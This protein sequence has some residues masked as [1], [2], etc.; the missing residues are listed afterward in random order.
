MCVCH[1]ISFDGCLFV[2]FFEIYVNDHVDEFCFIF[3]FECHTHKT[4]I[5]MSNAK[6]NCCNMQS[7][8]SLFVGGYGFVVNDGCLNWVNNQMNQRFSNFFI[9]S[10]IEFENH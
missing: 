2:F 8:S 1:L 3:E 6:F 4:N 5:R 10:M 7:S 9:H